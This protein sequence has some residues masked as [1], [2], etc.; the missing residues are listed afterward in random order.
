ML[1]IFLVLFS[2]SS[3]KILL[4]KD[5]SSFLYVTFF[6]AN[7]SCLVSGINLHID[8]LN[9]ISILFDLLEVSLVLI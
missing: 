9:C 5:F 3:I 8:L 1:F 6:F 2:I 7:L 4:S